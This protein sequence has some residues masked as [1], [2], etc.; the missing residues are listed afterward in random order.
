LIAYLATLGAETLP[1]R[2]LQI[3]SWTP[4]AEAIAAPFRAADARQQFVQRCA[5]CHGT[6]GRG[7][8]PLAAQLSLKP[9]DFLHNNWRHV[10]PNEPVREVALARI[11]KFG[12]PGTAMAGH[13]YLD[14]SSVVQLARFVEATHH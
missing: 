4:A 8:G 7:D 9:P 14:D 5:S 1:A 10:L 2:L 12:V 3:A 11:I 13:E 6:E